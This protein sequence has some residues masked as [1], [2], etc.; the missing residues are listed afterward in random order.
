MKVIE[1]PLKGCYEILPKIFE[2]SRGRLVKIFHNELFL[3]HNF[4]A[5]FAEEYYS[6]S[7]LN[8][9]RGLHFQLPPHDHIKCVTCI[10]GRLFDVVIDLRKESKTYK[11]HF[12]IELDAEKGNMLYIPKGFAHGFCALT[13]DV[14]FL[15]KTSTVY[16]PES[17]S[18]IHW[19]SCNINWPV[20]NPILSEKDRLM[21]DLNKFKSP[22]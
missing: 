16:N 20:E 1:T 5:E 19:N 12:S 17:D 15:N 18:G 3:E 22:F 21:I 11:Q 7:K 8:V 13:Q 6:T 2:D 14:I 10:R 4:E 9:I